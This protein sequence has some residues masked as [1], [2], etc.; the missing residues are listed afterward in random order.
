[1][2]G[3]VYLSEEDLLHYATSLQCSVSEVRAKLDRLGLEVR[4]AEEY[5]PSWWTWQLEEILERVK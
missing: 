1:M 5:R 3:A 2:I 4:P